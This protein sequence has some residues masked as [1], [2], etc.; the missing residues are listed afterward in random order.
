MNSFQQWLSKFS[1]L[2]CVIFLLFYYFVYSFDIFALLTFFCIFHFFAP[3]IFFLFHY[4]LRTY[5]LLYTRIV[6]P[7][8]Y[9]NVCFNIS[10]VKGKFDFHIGN[11]HRLLRAVSCYDFVNFL[12]VINNKILARKQTHKG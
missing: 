2:F 7:W 12:L 1:F 6:K 8:L 3:I 9:P 10:S 4:S 5:D 11:I